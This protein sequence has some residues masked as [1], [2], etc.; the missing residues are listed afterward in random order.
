M[1]KH[2][3]DD[4]LR[5]GSVLGRRP[6]ASGGLDCAEPVCMKPTMG[7]G[8]DIGRPPPMAMASSSASVRSPILR[9]RSRVKTGKGRGIIRCPL[10][11]CGGI[12]VPRYNPALRRGFLGCDQW[13][14]CRETMGEPETTW[15][16]RAGQPELPLGDG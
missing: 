6:T 15:M 11:S 16:R 14:R 2:Y 3:L 7:D 1:P 4:C 5:N 10:P 8:A 13:P 12:M 9:D